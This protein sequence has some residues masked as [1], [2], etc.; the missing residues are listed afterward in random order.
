VLRATWTRAS[1]AALD[2][3]DRR[4]AL[5]SGLVDPVRKRHVKRGS[6]PL[7]PADYGRVE[8]EHPFEDPQRR[9]TY[10]ALR[11]DRHVA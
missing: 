5:P 11:P 1:G 8:A 6:V 3:A 10:P 7:L 4:Y 2:A 9:A